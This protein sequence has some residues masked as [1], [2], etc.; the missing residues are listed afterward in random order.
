MESVRLLRDHSL[1][2]IWVVYMVER[3]SIITIYHTNNKLIVIV[4]SETS[5]GL[6]EKARARPAWALQD[7]EFKTKTNRDTVGHL[8]HYSGDS[9]MENH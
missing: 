1:R 2:E 4:I 3:Y 7:H 9:D 5:L 6:A 8:L